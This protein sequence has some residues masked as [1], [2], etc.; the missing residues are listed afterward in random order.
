MIEKY[1]KEIKE[2]IKE[3]NQRRYPDFL[4]EHDLRRILQR[5]DNE[6]SEREAEYWREEY[7]LDDY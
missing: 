4:I 2:Y 3:A 5:L 7:E 6:V 1:I